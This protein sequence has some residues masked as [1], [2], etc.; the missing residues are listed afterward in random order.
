MTISPAERVRSYD[1]KEGL[2]VRDDQVWCGVCTKLLENNKQ[3]IDRHIVCDSHKGNIQAKGRQR[4]MTEFI[5]VGKEFNADVVALMSQL[6]IPPR[7]MRYLRGF[8]SK[9]MP[10]WVQYM[11]SDPSKERTEFYQ[12]QMEYIQKRNTGHYVVLEVDE[13]DAPPHQFLAGH[14]MSVEVTADPTGGSPQAD[15]LSAIAQM[16]KV[17]G[18]GPNGG[19]E[20]SE[21]SA[22][23]HDKMFTERNHHK[24][25]L[26]ML[27]RDSVAYNRKAWNAIAP[28]FPNAMDVE[29]CGHLCSNILNEIDKDKEGTFHE[30]LKFLGMT[31]SFF[32]WSIARQGKW[33]RA[34][35]PSFEAYPKA[36]SHYWGVNIDRASYWLKP[37]RVALFYESFFAHHEGRLVA[38]TTVTLSDKDK[39]AEHAKAT[40]TLNELGMPAQRAKLMPQ[41]ALY[42][43]LSPCLPILAKMQAHGVVGHEQ[44]DLVRLFEQQVRASGCSNPTV[45]EYMD[46]RLGDTPTINVFSTMRLLHP[47]TKTALIST[48]FRPHASFKVPTELEAEWHTYLTQDH[49]SL[50]FKTKQHI[51]LFIL[52]SPYS[53]KFKEWFILL[54]HQNCTTQNIEAS[55]SKVAYTHDDLATRAHPQTL[56]EHAVLQCNLELTSSNLLIAKQRHDVNGREKRR[57]SQSEGTATT[58]G[59]SPSVDPPSNLLE[60]LDE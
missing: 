40:L 23:I 14:T 52:T 32:K 56:I 15:T 39:L 9:Y 22:F 44:F 4:K 17:V 28:F 29:C 5:D 53:P 7:K 55:F 1:K 31:K 58:D 59:S 21:V 46:K 12:N 6:N 35:G 30:L 54:L 48:G 18:R 60:D 10:E 43:K 2:L 36:T 11:P 42:T 16:S 19:L 13:A 8:F 20:A 57:K 27:K 45:N 26:V 34:L 33:E 41:L 3:T 37:G 51:E 25:C 47:V 49:S 24:S 50:V 38:P